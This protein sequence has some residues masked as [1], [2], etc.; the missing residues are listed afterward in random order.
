MTDRPIAEL[1]QILSDVITDA[2]TIAN[3]GAG[4]LVTTRQVKAVG[5]PAHLPAEDV[6][7]VAAGTFIWGVTPWGNG[8]WGT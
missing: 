8:V 3:A 7:T 1:G 4:R 2:A 6:D 5:S